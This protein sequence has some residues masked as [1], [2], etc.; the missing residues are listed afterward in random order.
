MTHKKD[1]DKEE[2]VEEIKNDWDFVDT[3]NELEKEIE[4]MIKA[5]ELLKWE[6]KKEEKELQELKSAIARSQADYHNLLKRVER[7]KI[8]MT[9]F[10]MANLIN[11]LLPFV[12]NLERIIESTP[13]E[14]QNNSLFEATKSTYNW[15]K[16]QFDDL[17]VKSFSSIWMEIDT[18]LHEV[19][20][21]DFWEKWIIIKEF[22]KG[23]KLQDKILRH[24]KVIVWNWEE[25]ELNPS[26]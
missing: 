1:D 12:D 6:V 10:I 24:A 26:S 17:W 13:N 8:D 20:W 5:E 22:E 7:D 23:Y 19:M 3:E 25:Q 18:N 14:L 21:Q 2:K 11:K 15:V 9:F 16:K 4:K